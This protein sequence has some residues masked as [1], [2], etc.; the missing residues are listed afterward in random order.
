ML[1]L[2]S[3]GEVSPNNYYGHMLMF[4]SMPMAVIDSSQ[5]RFSFLNEEFSKF[6]PEIAVTDTFDTHFSLP[7]GL[8]P[9]V[10]LTQLKSEAGNIWLAVT[11]KGV[12]RQ[13]FSFIFS[14]NK[15]E[16]NEVESILI[17]SSTYKQPKA[18][19]ENPFQNFAE[20]LENPILI[21]K[22]DELKLEVANSA[23]LTL[24]NVNKDAIGKS[25]LEILPEVK[26]QG[27]LDL[28]VN[29]YKN[30]ETH[31]GIESEF[32]FK[33][34]NGDT[35]LHFF[36][37]IYQPYREANDEITGVL[38]IASDVTSQVNAKRKLDI[39]E[40][41]FRNVI[42][43]A[44]VAMCILKGR[45]YEVEIANERMFEIWGRKSKEVTGKP[46][47]E[48]LPEARGQGL[49]DLL[50]SV[51]NTGK[52]FIAN[53]RPVDLP[54]KNGLETRY[55]NFVYEPFVEG[56]GKVT[57]II[58]VAVDVT[59]QILIRQK[60][61][62]AEESARLA[63]KSADLGTYEI[64]YT[65]NEMITSERFREIWNIDHATTDRLAYAS[66]IHPDDLQVR[67]EAHKKSLESGTVDYEARVQC[68]GD[69][70]TWVKI[71][72]KVIYNSE[73]KPEKLL[74]VIQDISE[75][76]QYAELLSQKI[77]L[78]TKKLLEAN[79]R[80]KKSNEELEQFAYVTSHD[81]QEPLRKIQFFTSVA[82]Q[83][84]EMP[85]SLHRN[86]EK[87]NASAKRMTDLIRGLLDYS[88]LSEKT[89]HFETIDLNLVA[90]N[91]L[92]DFELLI[93]QKNAHVE[94][95]HLPTITAIPL[96]MNQLFYNLIG[97]AL[98][99]TKKNTA[100]QITISCSE[101]TENL[102]KA[103]PQLNPLKNYFV[104]KIAD[105]GIGFSQE[106]A[107]KIFTIFQRLNERS[108]YAGY[109]IGLAICK[110]I[111][112]NHEGVIFAEGIPKEGAG[113]T[114]LLPSKNF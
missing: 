106:Y 68:A 48:A 27:F 39:S 112:E 14:A 5:F 109:G 22:G 35:D 7:A 52:A 20:Q 93:Q 81:L 94:K 11:S 1:K 89:S 38:I 34:P 3:E 79:E 13:E 53:E 12:D 77:D 101:A 61:Q 83:Q 37:F 50:N 25:I 113:F 107:D 29:V 4:T 104:I 69:K 74:G 51:I 110:R 42:L 6:F 85:E 23:L 36:N 108:V 64:N 88:K 18:P 78:S 54:R 31:Y 17:M 2:M 43:Q 15:N 26:E 9:A 102:I 73:G 98:K 71:K 75:Q 91:V 92:S 49:E 86:I 97:N 99:F 24:W 63:I 59:E 10:F 46:I 70:F 96:Q 58:A 47:F 30:G 95:D 72:G 56:D 105:N 82:L 16:L 65:T 32:Y 90:A 67:D 103:F 19:L 66:C 60:I 44:P 45:S 62:L 21:L 40:S 87:A 111:V 84:H 55:L 28:L 57:G 8:S 100:P 114:F 33:R 41:N 80:L 76:K